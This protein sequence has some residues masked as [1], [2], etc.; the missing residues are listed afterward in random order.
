VNAQTR[1]R[2]IT[3][4]LLSWLGLSPGAV[5]QTETG[6]FVLAYAH[7]PINTPLDRNDPAYGYR[8]SATSGDNDDSQQLLLIVNFSGGGTRAAAF[9]Y[10]ALQALRDARVRFDGRERSPR[11]SMSWPASR[12]AAS[13]P[14][15][16]H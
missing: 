4:L 6:L 11:R 5:A 14:R 7:F 13:Q 12:A 9:A 2:A 16:S 10:G 15:I 8:V 1:G 3:C